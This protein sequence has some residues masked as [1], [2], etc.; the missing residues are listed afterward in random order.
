MIAPSSASH[1]GGPYK[2][3]AIFAGNHSVSRTVYFVRSGAE[4]F[5]Q[6]HIV[7]VVARVGIVGIVV[8]RFIHSALVA[9]LG[10]EEL[11]QFLKQAGRKGEFRYS[12]YLTKHSFV[13]IITI[14]M[15]LEHS[16]RRAT[17][18]RT[19]RVEKLA[20]LRRPA[21]H[22]RAATVGFSRRYFTINEFL[23]GAEGE[24]GQAVG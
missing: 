7:D 21:A 12:S 1:L 18:S 14:T 11:W 19:T 15:H 3:I 17:S 8:V 9:R 5:V 6:R 24:D 10:E 20:D 2:G 13:T 4:G 22:S 16:R 23:K